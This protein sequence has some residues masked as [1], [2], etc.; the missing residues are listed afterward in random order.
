VR[1]WTVY[2]LRDLIDHILPASRPM[3]PKFFPVKS[4][5]TPAALAALADSGQSPAFFLNKH[6]QGDWGEACDEDKSL[7]DA[8]LVDGS[9]LL[10]AYRTLKG[11][12][13]RIIT[14]A[15]GEDGKR[16]ATT[17]LLPERY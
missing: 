17:V 12:K 9:R 1:R 3:K 14:E 7:N 13:L 4:F 11:V 5:A 8:A 10:S 6:I 15:V 16:A 2:L